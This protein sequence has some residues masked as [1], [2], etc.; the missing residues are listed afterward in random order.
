MIYVN[1]EEN[2]YTKY[3]YIIE[4]CEKVVIKNQTQIDY[5]FS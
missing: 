5:T 2:S 1:S 4:D 3:L